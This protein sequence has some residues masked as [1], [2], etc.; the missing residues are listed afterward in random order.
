MLSR[1]LAAQAPAWL[2]AAGARGAAGKAGAVAKVQPADDGITT[3]THGQAFVGDLR[4][5]SA[6]EVGDNVF[7]HTKKW[8]QGNHKSPIEYI[9][10]AEPIKVHG[11]V[12]ASYG[13]DDP[14]LGCPVEYIN[15]KGTTRENP[16]VCKYTGNKY[17]SDDWVGGGAH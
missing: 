1:R 17:Y 7:N 8:L 11:L 6:L 3:T 4:S 2:A 12:V 14:A 9:Q 5:T 16:A 15:L 13:Y 10:S